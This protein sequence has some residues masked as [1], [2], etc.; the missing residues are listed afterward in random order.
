MV[1]LV[2]DVAAGQGE[3]V[4]RQPSGDMEHS[5]SQQ[6]WARGGHAHLVLLHAHCPSLQGSCLPPG[7]QQSQSEAFYLLAPTVTPAVIR[8]WHNDLSFNYTSFELP[9]SHFT[10]PLHI[11]STESKPETNTSMYTHPSPCHPEEHLRQTQQVHSRKA[12]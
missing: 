4:G 11:T 12:S 7:L 10:S 5:A 6:G 8:L 2:P 3:A 9:S 1:F